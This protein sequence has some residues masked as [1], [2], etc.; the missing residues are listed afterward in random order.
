[1]GFPTEIAK[2][3]G[4]VRC[5]FGRDCRRVGMSAPLTTEEFLRDTV[6]FARSE[7]EKILVKLKKSKRR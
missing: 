5:G 1:M 6:A 2:V 7:K 4:A 3:S